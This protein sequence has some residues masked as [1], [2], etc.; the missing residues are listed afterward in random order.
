[1]SRSD[2]A[3]KP[4]PVSA[5]HADSTIFELA[6]FPRR[7]GGIEFRYGVLQMSQEQLCWCLDRGLT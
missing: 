7:E 2:I 3:A 4:V 1:M 5:R 6:P